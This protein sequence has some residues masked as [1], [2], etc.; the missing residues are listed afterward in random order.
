M[1]TTFKAA[2]LE[3]L[4]SPLVIDQLEVPD[5]DFGQV[6]VRLHRSGIC[7]A[8]LGEIAGVKGDDKYLPH[9]LGHEGGGVVEKV[10][11]GVTQ[12][13]VGDHVV[14][15]WRKGVGI[16]SSF[17]KYKRGG[18]F[19]GA[20]WITTFNECAV[21]SENRVTRIE[22]DIPFEVA[23]LMGCAVTTALGVV[24]NDAQLRIG[25]S[26]AIL[27]CGG[28][29]LNV[30]QGAAMVSGNPIIA[31][32]LYQHKLEMARDFGATHLI[33]SA[34]TDLREELRKIVGSAGVNVF[35]ETTGSAK[36]I[37][38]AYELT[39]PG[40]RTVLVGQLRH[41]MKVSIQTLPLHTGKLLVASEGG[42]TDPSIDIP[43]YLGLYRTGKL[44]LE[45]L[46]THQFPLDE[47][48]V[49]LDK[50]RQGD[51]GRCVLLL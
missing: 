18:G 43:R 1:A 42:Q 17:P 19:V 31:I 29:G 20:G 23:A 21:V 26:I 24:N 13:R 38:L 46:I 27:G 45:R 7:G 10:G 5:L 39:A 4:N 40:G 25:Q 33:N 22:K 48:N 6:L 28:V 11:P 36:L 16:N 9:L 2:V 49:A 47:I 12:V 15:H 35:V 34:T 37:E 44:K 41:D 32:D 50:I 3:K 51:V 8:Q 30:V 14:M